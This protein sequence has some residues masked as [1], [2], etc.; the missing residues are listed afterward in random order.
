[1]DQSVV[2][3][4]SKDGHQYAVNHVFL[5]PK[6]P[7]SGDDMRTAAHDAQILTALAKALPYFRDRVDVH[8]RDLVESAATAINRHRLVRCVGGDVE[9]H[10]LRDAFLA[11]EESGASSRPAAAAGP[12]DE[13]V[14]NSAF[15]GALFPST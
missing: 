10:R 13:H 1:M 14:A 11:M 12:R 4:F 15:Q 6:L 2:A 3:D 9:E 7:Q 5:P 8:C